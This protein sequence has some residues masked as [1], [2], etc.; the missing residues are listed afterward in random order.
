MSAAEAPILPFESAQAWEQWLAQN[1]TETAGIWLKIAKKDTGIA[2]VTH[3]EALDVA[4]CYG[5][6][7]GQG[8]SLDEAYFLQKFTPRRKRSIWSKRNTEKVTRLIAEGKMQPSGQAEVDAAKA[9]GRWD[10]AYGGQKGMEVPADFM[11]ALQAKPAALEFFNALNSANKFAIVF[12]L[13]TTKKPETRQRRFEA[14]LGMMERGE[15][16]H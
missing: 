13:T 1:Y 12:R 9:D 7:D 5:W 15:K 10:A 3:D 8:K 14:L 4:L 2:T 11:A 16:I 6:I